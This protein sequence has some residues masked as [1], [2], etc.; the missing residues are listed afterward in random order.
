MRETESLLIAAQSNT[1][2]INFFEA[3]IVSTQQNSLYNLCGDKYET[4]N[5]LMSE[6]SK[7]AQKE[8]KTRHDWVGKMIH[9]ELC[10]KLKFDDTSKWYKYKPESVFENETHEIIVNFEIQ[11][12]HLFPAR[13]SEKNFLSSRF[14]RASGPLRGNKRKQNDNNILGSCQRTW[15]VVE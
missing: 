11:T 13:K 12:D 1:I 14:I 9:E 7:L 8:Y 5:Y 2:R 15:K 6:F 4:V 10:K 3:K